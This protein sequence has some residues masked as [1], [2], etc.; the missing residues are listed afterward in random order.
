MMGPKVSV[1]ASSSS[2]R[3]R[4]DDRPVD[5]Q[6]SLRILADE[7]LTGIPRRDPPHPL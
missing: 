7:T 2:A 3:T 5:E 6:A 1:F 4:A